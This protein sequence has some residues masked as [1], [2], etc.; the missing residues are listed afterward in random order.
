MSQGKS[1]QQSKRSNK[2]QRRA[3]KKVRKARNK[4]KALNKQHAQK[5]IN[6]FLGDID[7]FSDYQ[8]HGNIKWAA[9]D[10][11]RIGL[12]LSWSEKKN[13]TDAFTETFKRC[14][15]MAITTVHTTYQGLIGALANYTHIFI[16]LSL[17][18]I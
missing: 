13:I 5:A 12:L 14:Q 1:T 11:T 7:I 2:T 10:L 17:I 6:S 18:H 16:P 9:S 3:K 15:R 8:F 4:S